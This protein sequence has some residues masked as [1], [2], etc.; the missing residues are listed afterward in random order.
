[1]GKRFAKQNVVVKV[2]PQEQALHIY[3]DKELIKQRQIK[4][5]YQS[6]MPFADYVDLIVQQ[7]IAEARRLAAIRRR[8][9][10]VAL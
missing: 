4:G 3:D 7:A 8:K 10:R 1:V 9:Y 2:K 5:L 6:K